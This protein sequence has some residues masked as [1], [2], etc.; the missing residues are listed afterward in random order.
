VSVVRCDQ[1]WA[2]RVAVSAASERSEI[3]D[4]RGFIGSRRLRIG[5]WIRMPDVA[6]L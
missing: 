2:E 1:P 6:P 3:A 5:L 4:E